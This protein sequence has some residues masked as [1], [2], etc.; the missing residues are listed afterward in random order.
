MEVFKGTAAF[1]GIAIGRIAEMNKADTVVRRTHVDD[2]DAEMARYM[3]AKEKAQEEINALRE[4]AMIEV[5]EAQAEIFEAHA[6]F[7]DDFDDSVDNI[8]REQQVNAEFAVAETGDN[9]AAMLAAMED[10]PYMQARATDVRDV[11]DRV[12]RIRGGKAVAVETN[13]HPASAET[14]EW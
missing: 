8:I 4:K 12:I 6:M 10:N 14:L 2:V 13:E 1:K 9:T 7:L 11:A 5:G 3:A